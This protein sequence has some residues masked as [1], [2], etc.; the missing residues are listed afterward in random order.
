MEDD[1]SKLFDLAIEVR[2]R[3]YAP[4]SGFQ[5]GAA[6]RGIDGR[7]FVGCNVENAAYPVGTCAEAG[8]ISSMVA[9]GCTQ[10]AEILIL[11]GEPGGPPI[12]PCGGCRQRIREFAGPDVLIHCVDPVGTYRTFTLDALLPFSFGPENLAAAPEAF[13]PV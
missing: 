6:V 10:I 9:F 4:Y 13:F 11:G 12:T 1:I 5:V 2:R 8:A 7:V 3:A